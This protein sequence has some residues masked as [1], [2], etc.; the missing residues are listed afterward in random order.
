MTME[1]PQIFIIVSLFT[2][3]VLNWVKHWEDKKEK[4]NIWIAILSA[5]LSMFIL[6][7]WWFFG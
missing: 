6:Y 1:R 3:I 7:H 4:Y 5:W 2:N